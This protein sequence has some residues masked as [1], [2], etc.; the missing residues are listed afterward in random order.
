MSRHA[1]TLTETLADYWSSARYEDLPPETVR[2]AKRH[3]IDTLS[4]GIAGAGTEV[5][6]IVLQALGAPSAAAG[7]ILW[8]RN[9]RLPAREAALLN[10]TASHA[11]ELDDFGGCG[12]SGAVVIPA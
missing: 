6:S 12:H 5:A 10:G 2:L 7:S 3:L 1:L 9:E 11:L 4:A 8:G